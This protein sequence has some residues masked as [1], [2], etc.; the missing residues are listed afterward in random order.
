MIDFY[1]K[2]HQVLSIHHP[3]RFDRKEA[4]MTISPYHINSVI[5]AYNKQNREKA[6]QFCPGDVTEK[7]TP[8]EVVSLS[9]QGIE[10]AEAY[11]KISHS[12]IDVI[13]KEK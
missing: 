4:C 7:E 1:L 8:A 2:F 13:L 10:E 5:S 6:G 11:K 12:L 9:E 3:D